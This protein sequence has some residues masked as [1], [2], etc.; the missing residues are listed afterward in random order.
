MHLAGCCFGIVRYCTL[1]EAIIIYSTLLLVIVLIISITPALNDDS[2]IPLVLV[3]HAA[4]LIRQSQF[5]VR[6]QS[7]LDIC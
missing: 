6:R 1:H 5:I 3:Q 2:L 7:G 4:K